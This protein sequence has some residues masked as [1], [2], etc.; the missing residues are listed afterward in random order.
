MIERARD[1]GWPAVVLME[2]DCRWVPAAA[3]LLPRVLQEVPASADLVYLGCPHR[4]MVATRYS[5]HLRGPSEFMCTHAYVLFTR[6][7]D[8][9]L[10]EMEGARDAYDVMLREMRGLEAYGSVPWLATQGGGVS[11]IMTRTTVRSSP[12]DAEGP[13][14]LHLLGHPTHPLDLTQHPE[15]AQLQVMRNVCYML[16]QARQ[17][18]LYYGMRGSQ[19]PRLDGLDPVGRVVDLGQAQGPWIYGNDWHKIYTDRL[20]TAMDQEVEACTRSGQLAC[21]LYG[22]AHGDVASHA[23]PLIVELAAGYPSVW[24][25]YKVF[26]S[27]TWQAEVYATWDKAARWKW[28]DTVLPHPIAPDD[29]ARPTGLEPGEDYALFIGRPIRD[30]GLHLAHMACGGMLPLHV[31]H[32]GLVLADKVREMYGAVAVL[33]PSEYQEP[34]GLVAVEA[35]MCGTPVVTT[36]WGAF[37]ETVEHGRTGFRCRTTAEFR[38]ALLRCAALD[39]DYIR[40]RARRLY[41]PEALWPAYERYCRFVLAIWRDGYTAEDAR[42]W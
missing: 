41:S 35:Q 7:Y 39:R 24:S 1:E 6:A 2:D 14:M 11:D 42:R 19:L 4:G 3:E 9:I 16:E 32:K 26:P 31:H 23:R 36:D 5:R 21:S 13:M 37:A 27:Y 8:R 20:A 17:S 12:A 40:A 33:A 34:F 25:P 10:A 28:F 18:Y 22:W 38:E 30:K 29:Y 15:D